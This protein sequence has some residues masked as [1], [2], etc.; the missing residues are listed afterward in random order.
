MATIRTPTSNMVSTDNTAST[1]NIHRTNILATTGG[2][3]TMINLGTTT[4]TKGSTTMG[5]NKAVM[6]TVNKGTISK[7]I[8]KQATVGD[9]LSICTM[10]APFE[11]GM[12]KQRGM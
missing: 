2:N 9:V 6:I 8:N 7:D 3:P 10:T 1:A 11:G 5:N 12:I 4:T